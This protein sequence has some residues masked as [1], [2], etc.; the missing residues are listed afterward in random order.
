VAL[1]LADLDALD[2]DLGLT[3]FDPFQIDEFLF[4]DTIAPSA[5]KAPDP[6]GNAVT[7]LGDLWR[8]GDTHRV[9]AGDATSPESVALLFGSNRPKLLLTDPP[10]G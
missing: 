4:P 8:F 6:P 7:R 10:L 2:F 5:E 1:E 3:G 9:L